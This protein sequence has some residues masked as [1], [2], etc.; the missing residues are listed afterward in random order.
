MQKNKKNKF[1]LIKMKMIKI[2]FKLTSRGRVF[3]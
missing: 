3:Q 1:Q 2:I